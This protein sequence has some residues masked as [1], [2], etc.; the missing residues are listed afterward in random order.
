MAAWEA[1]QARRLHDEE[2]SVADELDEGLVRQGADPNGGTA[3]HWEDI[4]TYCNALEDLIDG[5]LESAVEKAEERLAAVAHDAAR[6]GAARRALERERAVLDKAHSELDK[7]W[8]VVHRAVVNG[9]EDVFA[10]LAC[11]DNCGRLFRD[12][13]AAKAAGQLHPA[14]ESRRREVIEP[15]LG[16]ALR[17]RFPI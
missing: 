4:R 8:P 12:T 17:E 14:C 13:R 7:V 9:R 6:R 10:G 15:T 1:R 5:H 3:D 11:R 16:D 2:Q